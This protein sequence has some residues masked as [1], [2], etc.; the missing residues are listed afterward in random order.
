MAHILVTYFAGTPTERLLM[1]LMIKF[2][3]NYDIQLRDKESSLVTG[4]DIS[5]AD[6]I[7]VIRPYDVTATDI[8]R[9][10]KKYG[11]CSI[12]YLDDDLLHIPDLR[13]NLLR[14]II[15]KLLKKR[16][17]TELKKSL[18]MCDILWGSSP[19]L[20]D[21][22]KQ[23]V[24]HGRCIRCDVTADITRMKPI[25]ME[26]GYPHILFAGG[27]DHAE[28]LN[29]YVIPAIN[30][31]AEKYPQLRFTCMGITKSQLKPC[32]IPI[33]FIPWNN[34]YEEYCRD[35]EKERYHIGIA[36]IEDDDFYKCK[37]YNKFIEYSLLGMMGIYTKCEPYSLIVQHGVNGLLADTSVDSWVENISFAIEHPQICKEYVQNA[38]EL[39]REKF[40]LEKILDEMRKTMPEI[41][42][43]HGS[44]SAKVSYHPRFVRNICKKIVMTVIEIYEK[45]TS[46][47][48]KGND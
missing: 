32:R 7:L 26:S 13:I 43:E 27:S 23:Y 11:K 31:I 44:H 28:L 18:S 34:N 45:Y 29:R 12:V 47:M 5:W 35:V 36:V 40:Q 48:G 24:Q 21:K 41:C 19:I 15:S 16:N 42:E 37:Y 39:V 14:T 2:S 22:Y 25:D 33:K 6:S 46:K 8:I 20:V 1:G 38:Q 10:A 3:I 9:A 17:Q 30:V 4:E